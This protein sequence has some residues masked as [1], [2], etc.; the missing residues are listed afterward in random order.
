MA[1]QECLKEHYEHYCK[2]F[3]GK[4]IVTGC[5]NADAR[6]L[7]IGEAP[8][9][10]EVRLSKPFVG[11]AGKQL[12][13]FLEFLDIER[14]SIYITNAI[15]YRLSK[16]SPTTGRVSN[17]PA[18]REEINSSRPYLLKEIEIIRP[19]IIV[20]LGNVPLRALT[21]DNS[22]SIGF[23]HGSIKKISISEEE[24]D[25]FPLYHPASLIYNR[26]L[27]ETYLNDLK[28]LKEIL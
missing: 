6:L 10:E 21:G 7:L 15:K 14:D 16:T 1:K 19:N 9:R 4:E 13:E 2:E 20:T 18:A 11:A 25:L 17:R 28:A 24:Y 26:S 5:G 12:C 8:G 22:I 3:A 23:I 27:K